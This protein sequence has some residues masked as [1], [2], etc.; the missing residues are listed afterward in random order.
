M[1]TLTYGFISNHNDGAAQK[2]FSILFIEIKSDWKQFTPEI[3]KKFDSERNKRH[4]RILCN[5]NSRLLSETIK[6]LAVR[7]ETLVRKA[8][9]SN[10]QNYKSTKM[11]KILMMTLT[12]QLGNPLL[13]R[14][15]DIGFPKLVNKLEQAETTIK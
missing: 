7:I 15:F 11:A 4:Q 13:I 9:S 6:L 2:W 12:A 14:N 8:Y 3:S 5:G 10:K 1:D